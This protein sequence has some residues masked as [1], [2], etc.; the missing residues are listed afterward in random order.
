MVSQWLNAS[1]SPMYMFSSHFSML[2]PIIAL[3]LGFSELHFKN[4]FFN[5]ESFENKVRL[6]TI[7]KHDNYYLIDL[8]L[9]VLMV[10]LPDT[11]VRA[12]SFGLTSNLLFH[13]KCINAIFHNT[14]TL[15]ITCFNFFFLIIS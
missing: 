5:R 13:D 3:S 10:L 14:Y 1:I 15:L 12:S 11:T 2:L 6:L 4:K 9:R 7:F 8:Y